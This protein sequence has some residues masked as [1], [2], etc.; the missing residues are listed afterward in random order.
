MTITEAYEAIMKMPCRYRIPDFR[1][2]GRKKSKIAG[3][4]E[5]LLGEAFRRCGAQALDAEDHYPV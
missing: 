4:D 3:P 2:A 1:E 5:D